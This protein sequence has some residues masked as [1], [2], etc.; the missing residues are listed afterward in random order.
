VTVC[1]NLDEGR[2]FRQSEG[3]EAWNIKQGGGISDRA[4][5]SRLAFLV[6]VH[7][8]V[9]SAD[10][11]G[12][13]PRKEIETW[14][15]HRIDAQMLDDWVYLRGTGAF[16]LAQIADFPHFRCRSFLVTRLVRRI[17]VLLTTAQSTLVI[18]LAL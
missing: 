10:Q 8:V 2:D 7:V 12:A 5:T 14:R 1:R 3:I 13:E 6:S 15:R 4:P 18:V 11:C 16:V 17:Q 9:D